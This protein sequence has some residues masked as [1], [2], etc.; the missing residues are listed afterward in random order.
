MKIPA[1]KYQGGTTL[2]EPET[3]KF[4]D[5]KPPTPAAPQERSPIMSPKS[6]REN[7]ESPAMKLPQLN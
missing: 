7:N 5:I 6:D 1:K 3:Q 4:I 2:V